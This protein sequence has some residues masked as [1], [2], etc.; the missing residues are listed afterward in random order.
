MKKIVFFVVGIIFVLML[1]WATSRAGITWIKNGKLG[2]WSRQD[3][4]WI[5]SSNK[6]RIDSV[7]TSSTVYIPSENLSHVTYSPYTHRQ[8]IYFVDKNGPIK[9]A[10][11]DDFTSNPVETEM[12]RKLLIKAHHNQYRYPYD[13]LQEV[14]CRTPS[15]SAPVV[16]NNLYNDIMLAFACNTQEFPT[17]P[18]GIFLYLEYYT[19]LKKAGKVPIND[20]DSEARLIEGGRPAF[21][22]VVL[23][24]NSLIW[25]TQ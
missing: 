7:L 17:N 5:F 22:K 20:L 18:H 2:L 11:L 1:P 23:L 15:E 25:R 4:V 3:N 8:D 6:N 10:N 13:F 16:M 12:W 19:E 21:R 9:W 24:P 14:I